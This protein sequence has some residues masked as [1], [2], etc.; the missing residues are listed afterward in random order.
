MYEL[1]FGK[2][3]RYVIRVYVEFVLNKVR[4]KS[5][6]LVGIRCEMRSFRI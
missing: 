4:L 5:M 2:L 6:C 3:V 1:S